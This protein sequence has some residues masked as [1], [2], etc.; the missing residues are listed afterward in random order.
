MAKTI[1]N[2]RVCSKSCRE[3]PK[4]KIPAKGTNETVWKLIKNAKVPPT[5]QTVKWMSFDCHRFGPWR[6]PRQNVQSLNDVLVGNNLAIIWKHN[7]QP[8]WLAW[9]LTGRRRSD[10]MHSQKACPM[11][12][13][14]GFPFVALSF[15][16][17]NNIAA[18]HTLSNFWAHWCKWC[19]GDD[20]CGR[21]GL[22]ALCVA[23][24]YAST[25][26]TF[27]VVCFVPSGN[28]TPFSVTTIACTTRCNGQI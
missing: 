9:K 11:S 18:L 26:N 24:D 1:L 14:S 23:Q 25:P 19:D 4:T 16:S 10:A 15:V 7:T 6:Q 2:H 3:A 27:Q 5:V 22:T 21:E 8:T 20:E 12:L 28:T 13:K 17:T